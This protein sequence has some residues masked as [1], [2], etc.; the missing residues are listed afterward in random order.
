L[1]GIRS[2]LRHLTLNNKYS[3]ALLGSRA[4]ALAPEVEVALLNWVWHHKD[5]IGYLGQSMYLPPA[6]DKPP[7]HLD[8]WF[9]SLELPAKFP[10]WRN[11]AGEAMQWLWN[12]QRAE[13]LWDFGPRPA[14]STVLPLSESWR[15]KVARQFDWTT[16]VLMLL[17]A[18]K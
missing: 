18:N 11:L 9:R 6:V 1:T 16:R 17:R 15:R 4:T 10:S 8:A 14:F 3:L 12:E 13:G 5:G 7:G 2:E